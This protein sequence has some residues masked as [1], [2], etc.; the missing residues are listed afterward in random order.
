M[1][2]LRSREITL[3]LVSDLFQT[4][5]TAKYFCFGRNTD[6][7]KSAAVKFVRTKQRVNLLC[8]QSDCISSWR[9]IQT[10]MI[11][12][13]TNSKSQSCSNIPAHDKFKSLNRLSDVCKIR[14]FKTVT[15]EKPQNLT[16]KRNTL[17]HL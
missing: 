10:I 15:S 3:Q 17:L 4:L 6:C 1:L 9:C 13:I 11:C 8:I 5:S 14:H 7:S 2:L 16:V 12:D